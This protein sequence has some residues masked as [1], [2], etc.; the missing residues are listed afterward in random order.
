MSQRQFKTYGLQGEPETRVE[1]E[2]ENIYK[3]KLDAELEKKFSV[4]SAS[5]VAK[6]KPI[7]VKDGANWYIYIRIEDSWFKAALTAV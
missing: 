6:G 2:L 4:P 7:L 5:T 1:Q 3:L